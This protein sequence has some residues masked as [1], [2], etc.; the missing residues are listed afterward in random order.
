[1]RKYIYILINLLIISLTV[2]AVQ[3][4]YLG[5]Q[6]IDGGHG[7]HPVIALPLAT[8]FILLALFIPRNEVV[9]QVGFITG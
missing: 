9:L 7:L 6:W 3:L 1:M 2:L 8:M 5:Y 4:S